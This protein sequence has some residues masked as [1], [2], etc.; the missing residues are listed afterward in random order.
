MFLSYGLSPQKQPAKKGRVVIPPAGLADVF[1]EQTAWLVEHAQGCKEPR[2]PQVCGTCVRF[3]KIRELVME[4]FAEG[5]KGR[6]V[7]WKK[8]SGM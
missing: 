2:G 7:S 1:L 4:I 6:S 8:A 5:E 3:S